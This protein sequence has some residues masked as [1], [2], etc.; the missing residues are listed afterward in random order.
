LE[1]SLDVSGQLLATTILSSGGIKSDE[2]PTV[3]VQLYLRKG[4]YKYFQ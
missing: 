3:L 1:K 2:D 4:K